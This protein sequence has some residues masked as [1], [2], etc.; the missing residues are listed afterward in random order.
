MNFELTP[1]IR[2]HKFLIII[3]PSVLGSVFM[4]M[5]MF[6]V[7]TFLSV[8]VFCFAFLVFAGVRAQ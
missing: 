1:L 3:Q 6:L 2:K 8:F 4:F 7:F 5:F